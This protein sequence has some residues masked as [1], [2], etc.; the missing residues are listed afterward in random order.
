MTMFAGR[1]VR[2]PLADVVARQVCDRRW[3]CRR[4]A[5]LP[6]WPRPLPSQGTLNQP[7]A[8]ISSSADVAI[9]PTTATAAATSSSL[10]VTG[11]PPNLCC[12][13]VTR[14]KSPLARATDTT[15][16]FRPSAPDAGG[17]SPPAPD[18][19]WSRVV[20]ASA[21][22]EGL[23]SGGGL[24][25]E[26]D[27]ATGMLR[28][29]PAREG[30]AFEGEGVDGHDQAGAGHGQG[31]DLGPQDQPEG[32]LEDAGGDRQGDGVVADR[33]AQVLAHL[34]QGAPS[35]LQG[36]RDIQGVRAH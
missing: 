28:L 30:E 3:S 22:P 34:A 27:W 19:S 21:A 4:L 25:L 9:R 12:R 6:G 11:T 24:G 15:D 23:A 18:P 17:P 13:A 26:C 8:A 33:P 16:D 14:A 32:G 31:G 35:D 10:R 36:G 5:L 29:L 1:G 7:P 20:V 2:T